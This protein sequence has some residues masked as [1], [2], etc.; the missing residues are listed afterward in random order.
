MAKP[1]IL[2]FLF[3]SDGD[4]VI[5]TAHNFRGKGCEEA[6]NAFHSGEATE[7]GPTAEY[8][9]REEQQKALTQKQ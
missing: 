7:S 4:E 9:Q 3:S 2:E 5:I 8:Y 1:K 6:V